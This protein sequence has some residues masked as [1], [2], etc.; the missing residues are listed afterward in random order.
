[1]RRGKEAGSRLDFEGGAEPHLG[2][3]DWLQILEKSELAGVGEVESGGLLEGFES[4][5]G[6][7]S[8][9]RHAQFRAL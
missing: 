4:L 6:G 9:R 3:Q 5:R 1:M 2:V 7:R 8:K